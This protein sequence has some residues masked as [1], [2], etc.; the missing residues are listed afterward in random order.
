MSIAFQMSRR[1]R[2]LSNLSGSEVPKARQRPLPW[3]QQSDAR[4]AV[5]SVER[6]RHMGV[7]RWRPRCPRLFSTSE[8]ARLDLPGWAIRSR[9]AATCD[10]R[11][12][13]ANQPR[14]A[15]CGLKTFQLPGRRRFD[16]AS[17]PA[18][19]RR[20]S[21]RGTDANPGSLRAPA[22][23]TWWIG[24]RLT[25]CAT[26]RFIY[27]IH[28]AKVASRLPPI[29]VKSAASFGSGPRWGSIAT[30]SASKTPKSKRT[31]PWWRS[32]FLGASG[33]EAIFFGSGFTRQRHLTMPPDHAGY[34]SQKCFPQTPGI[35]PFG[36]FA[37]R[38]VDPPIRRSCRES[39]RLKQV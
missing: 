1:R 16:R 21:T 19:K 9:P 17:R 38:S 5:F 15:M 25:I 28:R 39:A 13:V 3:N 35:F 6:K 14:E 8:L 37:K 29:K 7:A 27:I 18:R 24:C 31:R 33:F 20:G 2:G 26:S 11:G 10:L 32:G 22:A 12:I 4:P 34:L 30:L 23:G 36:G